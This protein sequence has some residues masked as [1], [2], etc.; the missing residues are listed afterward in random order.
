SLAGCQ[1]SNAESAPSK[2]T[3]QKVDVKSAATPA[4]PK[5]KLQTISEDLHVIFGPGGNIG[6]SLGPDG[7]VIVD[8]KFAA[9]GDEILSLLKG[10]TDEPLR[11]VIN[12]HYHGDHTGSNGQMKSV[13]ATVVA[14]DNVRQRMSMAIENKLFKRTVEPAPKDHWPSLTF[15]DDMNF[16]MNGQ[17]VSLHHAPGHTDG[18]SL[19]YFKDVNVIHMGD[20]YF[21]GLFPYIDIDA[22]GSVQG[23]IAAHDKALSMSDENTQIIPGHGPMSTREDLKQARDM[24]VDIMARVESRIAAGETLETI[25][26]SNILL[27]YA[28]YA[29]FIDEKNMIRIAHRSLTRRS[30]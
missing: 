4:E 14:H 2:K 10:L 16:H 21:N 12:T 23:M 22:G 6:V 30:E 11:F 20:N 18:D 26:D 3:T 29:S 8:D 17:T 9:N 15:S 27:D 7:V 19:V 28:D 1:A 13:G 25:L 24:L 5:L